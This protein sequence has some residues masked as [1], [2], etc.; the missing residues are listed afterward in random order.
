[1]TQRLLKKIDAHPKLIWYFS[2]PCHTTPAPFYTSFTKY[3]Y[4]P[5]YTPLLPTHTVHIQH[6]RYISL[7]SIEYNNTTSMLTRLLHASSPKEA[8]RLLK[9]P[10][11]HLVTFGTT[12]SHINAYC[13]HSVYSG[14]RPYA[15]LLMCIRV[16]HMEQLSWGAQV[17]HNAS[18]APRPCKR[19]AR[20][21]WS[22]FTC[23]LYEGAHPS[24]RHAKG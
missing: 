13:I 10:E 1:M 16:C 5:L 15:F 8:V 9:A 22:P 18:H 3:V 7:P 21:L 12:F 20:P 24:R 19:Q 6:A 2:Q 17:H 11:D 4:T 23:F 14:H